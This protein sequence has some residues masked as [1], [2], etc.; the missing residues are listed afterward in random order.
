[1]R[2]ERGAARAVAWAAIPIVWCAC[3]TT[4]EPPDPIEPS[5]LACNALARSWAEAFSPEERVSMRAEF[6]CHVTLDLDG[7]GMDDR[8]SLIMDGTRIGLMVQRQGADPEYIG[9]RGGSPLLYAIDD[10]PTEFSGDFSFLV[11][12][13]RAERRHPDAHGEALWMSSTDVALLLYL[14]DDGWVVSHLGY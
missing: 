4:P 13:R 9:T 11:A 12:W 1:M 5:T 14:N 10:T 6:P 8:V 2:A 7:D 3:A